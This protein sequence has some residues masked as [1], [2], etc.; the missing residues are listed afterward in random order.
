[1]Q[2]A[3]RPHPSPWRTGRCGSA[4]YPLPACR[5]VPRDGYRADRCDRAAL[6]PRGRACSEGPGAASDAERLPLRARMHQCRCVGLPVV[7]GRLLECR[8]MAALARRLRIVRSTAKP[9]VRKPGTWPRLS[10]PVD[11]ISTHERAALAS[12]LRLDFAEITDLR[13]LARAIRSFP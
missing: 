10:A 13:A 8:V 7:V 6:C 12:F 3:A 4:R 9:V 11:P 2:A 1:R 5:R